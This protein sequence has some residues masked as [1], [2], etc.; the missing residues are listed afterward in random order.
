LRQAYGYWQDQPGNLLFKFR[1]DRTSPER[2]A[3]QPSSTSFKFINIHEDVQQQTTL[4][5]RQ[6]DRR[7]RSRESIARRVK[8]ITKQYSFVRSAPSPAE[9]GQ[10]PDVAVSTRKRRNS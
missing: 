3:T 4:P 7:S 8:S 10:N 2:R 6:I 9:G 5:V 1:R